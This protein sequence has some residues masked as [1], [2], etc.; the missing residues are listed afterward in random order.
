MGQHLKIAIHRY[1]RDHLQRYSYLVQ[2][3]LY[4]CIVLYSAIFIIIFYCAL[5]MT[6]NILKGYGK[7]VSFSCFLNTCTAKIVQG[8]YSSSDGSGFLSR[9]AADMKDLSPSV[10]C[11]GLGTSKVSS[12]A[13]RR[14]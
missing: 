14:L 4:V 1:V 7:I 11:L 13:D 10:L 6:L 2:V 3:Y 5:H 9:G 12:T 8:T